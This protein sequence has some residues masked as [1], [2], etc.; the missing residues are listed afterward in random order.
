MDLNEQGNLVERAR[1]DLE[2]LGELY[3]QYYSR[4]FGYV[5]KRT[6]SV[7]TAQD[8]TS[9]VFPIYV[10]VNRCKTMRWVIEDLR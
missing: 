6:A 9:E 3:D 8:I 7:Q 4:I 1:L 5:L 10:G 2:A